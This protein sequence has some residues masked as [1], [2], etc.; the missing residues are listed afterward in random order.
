MCSQLH[1]FL[2]RL[3]QQAI[4]DQLAKKLLAGDVRDGDAVVVGV[5]DDG[6]SL[7]VGV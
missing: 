1:H 6:E 4:G 2:C 7:K 3:V 5:A